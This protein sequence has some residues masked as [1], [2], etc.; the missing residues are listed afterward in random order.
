MKPHPL[1]LFA[2]VFSLVSSP[3]HAE[4]RTSAN[5]AVAADSAD[6]GGR[7]AASA[8]Y[9]QDGSVGLVAGLSTVSAATAKHGFVAQLFD[10]AALIVGS[11]SSD[12]EESGTLQ[13]SSRQLLDDGTTLA[14]SA[15]AVA[16]SQPSAPLIGISP[17]GLLTSG[18]VYQDSPASIQGKYQGFTGS[19]GL[20]VLDAITDNFGSYAG[21]GIGDDWQVQ[22]FGMDN[23]LAAPG[24]DPDGDGQPNHFEYVAS[25]VP[26]DSNSRF[27]VRIEP[28]PEHPMQMRVVF[29]P[30]IEGRTYTVTTSENLASGS[31]NSLTSSSTADS[32]SERSV[33]DLSPPGAKRFYRVNIQKP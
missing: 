30:R 5:Y 26:T 31:W 18:P 2:C 7:R 14:I 27:L 29:S 6:S 17:A 33:T 15:G 9:V 11:A 22:Y 32:G 25:I 3:V 4:S 19:L 23:P 8:N 1:L 21:D 16:W 10:A 24:S 12:I 28:A 13:L 20:T